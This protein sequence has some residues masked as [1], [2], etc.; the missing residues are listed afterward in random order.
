MKTPNL[1]TFATSELSQDAFFGWFISWAQPNFR[2]IDLELN[3]SALQLLKLIFKSCD[4]KFPS[5]DSV[6]VLKQHHKID[7]LVIVNNKY[8]IIIEDKTK[9]KN[10]SNQ[11]KRYFESIRSKEGIREE[12]ILKIYLKTHEQSNYHQIR[13]EGYEPIKRENI[14]SIL[15]S[16]KTSNQILIDYREYLRTLELSYT[17]YK[18][19][20]KST[21]KWDA[22]V[23]VGLF[24]EI[25]TRLLKDEL[26]EASPLDP[27]DAL[28]NHWHSVNPPSGSFMAFFWG[29]FDLMDDLG[30]N[31]CCFMLLEE[32]KFTYKVGWASRNPREQYL[33]VHRALLN[34]NPVSGFNNQ[35]FNIVKPKRMKLSGN[36]ATIGI[37]EGGYLKFKLDGSIDI[38][39]TYRFIKDAM[40]SLDILRRQFG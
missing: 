9:S 26:I 21:K 34:L 32:D 11:L 33:K 10:H 8:Y 1:F 12:D 35:T 29:G 13:E 7:L 27:N 36:S 31:G 39:A 3:D 18:Y 30:A 40:E 23:W 5:L 38:D 6:K 20:V 4:K 37:I 19:I 25:Q 14:L 17:Q 24:Q 2:E 15:D 22:A 28:E 16:C